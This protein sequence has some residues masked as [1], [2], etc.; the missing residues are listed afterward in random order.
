MQSNHILRPASQGRPFRADKLKR[1]GNAA[2]KTVALHLNLRT[3]GYFEVRRYSSTDHAV[4]GDIR[5]MKKGERRPD[6]SRRDGL[7]ESSRL[8][9][10][11]QN[12]Y[13]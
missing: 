10:G 2:L 9:R 1:T 11:P 13:A 8:W 12:R 6:E 4:Q 7:C 3:P 5:T